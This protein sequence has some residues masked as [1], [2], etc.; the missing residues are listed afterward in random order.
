MLSLV[1]IS[2]NIHIMI[3]NFSLLILWQKILKTDQFPSVSCSFFISNGNFFS[4][5]RICMIVIMCL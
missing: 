1:R 5:A 3:W 2:R 4:Y